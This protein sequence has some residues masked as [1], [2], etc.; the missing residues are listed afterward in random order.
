MII[1]NDPW[2]KNMEEALTVVERL[3]IPSY[4]KNVLKEFLVR[5]Q[6]FINDIE[7]IALVGSIAREDDFIEGW[8]DIDILIV[9]RNK[10]VINAI[11]NVVKQLNSKCPK[12]KKN[13]GILSLWID[14][15]D[16]VLKWLG[17]GCE[18]YNI[19]KN[20]ILLYGNDIRVKLKEPSKEELKRTLGY[21]AR[22]AI[23]YLLKFKKEEVLNHIDTLT[24]A[25]YIYPL[26]RFYLCAHGH[27]TASRK[28]MIEVLRKRKIKTSL[29]NNELEALITVLEDLLAHRQRVIPELNK[30]VIKAIEK[31]INEINEYSKQ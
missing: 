4:Y 19:M 17:L 21:M 13:S 28:E 25:N 8:S 9:T 2:V 7:C 11:E 15:K 23:K 12:T 6:S 3:D 26:M 20:F 14:D 16:N 5:L 27:P 31:I 1:N 10:E 29:S 24:L 18:Y 30:T 22:E